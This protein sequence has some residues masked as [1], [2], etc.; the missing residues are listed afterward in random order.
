MQ[1]PAAL[2]EIPMLAEYE[3]EL[4]EPTAQPIAGMTA[5]EQ[6]FGV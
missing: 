3:D 6:P 5:Q 2:A 1:S 4:T